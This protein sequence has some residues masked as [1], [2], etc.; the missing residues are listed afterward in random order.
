MNDARA[1]P[2]TTPLPTGTAGFVSGFSAFLVGLKL[3]LPGGG[4]FRYAL[5]PII[6]SMFVA[7]G[8]A[9]GA[10]FAAKYWMVEWLQESWAGWLGGVLAFVLTLVI[11]YFLFVPVMSM[12]APLFIDP[13]C[14]KVHQRYTGTDLIGERSAQQFLK[15][16]LFALVQSIK[17][18][19]VVLL[20]QLPLAISAMLT[21]VMAAV[22]VPVSAVIMGADLLDNPL[23]L[24]DY[25][26]SR[27]LAFLKQNFWPAAGLGTA[28]SL[29]MLVPGLNLF[30][31]TAGAA[32]ATLLMVATASGNPE[33]TEQP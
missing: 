7:T 1:L 10:F 16:Q 32:A 30:V 22:A 13:I 29:L 11:A 31:P 33:S 9:V 8:V 6:L 18:L 23:S 4:L 28:A 24:R 15:R 20:I 2:I 17:W 14:E 25:N 27:K 21:G 3:V 19:L 5:A 26:L 12:F